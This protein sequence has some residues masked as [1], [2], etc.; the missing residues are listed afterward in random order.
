MCTLWHKDV[1]RWPCG[2]F[3]YSDYIKNRTPGGMHLAVP[4]TFV[5]TMVAIR[6]SC[7]RQGTV[8]VLAVVG[9]KSIGLI[10]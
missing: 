5:N 7:A 4:D 2:A 9:G 1:Q 6:D 3:Y 8:L 10:L